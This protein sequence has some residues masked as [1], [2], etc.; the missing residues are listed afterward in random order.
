MNQKYVSLENSVASVQ[1]LRTIKYQADQHFSQTGRELDY[2]QHTT[3]L[4]STETNYD[5][6]FNSLFARSPRKVCNTELEGSDFE[7]D[8]PSEVTED[9]DY[10]IDA[11][12]TTLL[13]NMNKRGNSNPES[14]LPSV[15]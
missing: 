14:Y 15:D 5:T 13:A 2:D 10:D 9:P 7:L 8:S 3:L 1:P 4:F 11:S 12:E 6:Q